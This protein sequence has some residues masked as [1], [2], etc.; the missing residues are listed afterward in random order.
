[1]S[2]VC[3]SSVLIALSTIGQ[4][5]LLQERF[6]DKELIIPPGVLREVV[7]EG[8][9]QPG[10][11]EVEGATWIAVRPLRDRTLVRLLEA[12]LDRGEAEAI[13]IAS[14]IETE[15]VL[16]DEK[17][18]RQVAERMGFKTLGTIGIL[19]WAKREGFIPSLRE[20]LDVLQEKGKFRIK[21]EL[22]RRALREAGKVIG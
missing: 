20:Q 19:L 16:L 12:E 2:I 7:E 10:A 4:L 3:N 17:D 6:K 18:A 13:A 22:Y 5:K 14:E 1:V 8:R 15:V 9:D 21:P 11:K